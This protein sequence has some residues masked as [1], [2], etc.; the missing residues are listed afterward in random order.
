MALA[1][2]GGCAS[3][4]DEETP[5][6]LKLHL[7]NNAPVTMLG[8]RG[9]AR[10]VRAAGWWVQEIDLSEYGCADEDHTRPAV[11]VGGAQILEH[12]AAMN[13]RACQQLEQQQSEGTGGYYDGDSPGGGA[14]S[15]G[16]RRAHHQQQQRR[17]GAPI[18]IMHDDL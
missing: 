10:G 14:A 8:M 9:L 11:Q 2:Q 13:M 12:A 18:L 1:A 16:A 7:G 15:A 4:R 6:L 17:R 5:G 3:S